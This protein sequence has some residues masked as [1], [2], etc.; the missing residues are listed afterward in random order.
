M[1]IFDYIAHDEDDEEISVP[2]GASISSQSPLPDAH[3]LDTSE[4]EDDFDF[5]DIGVSNSGD[6]RRG[7]PDLPRIQPNRVVTERQRQR[8][9]I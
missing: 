7:N 9:E 1:S 4:S 6:A 8:R 5:E 2:L 3:L